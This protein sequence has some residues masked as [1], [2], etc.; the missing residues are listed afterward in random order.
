MTVRVAAVAAALLLL[1]AVQASNADADG[2]SE[3]VPANPVRTA[4][5]GGPARDVVDYVLGAPADRC[6]TTPAARVCSWHLAPGTRAHAALVEDGDAGAANAPVHVVCAFTESPD[7]SAKRPGDCSVHHPG[8][9]IARRG[10]TLATLLPKDEA[11]AALAAASDVEALARAFGRAPDDCLQR[12]DEEWICS[13]VTRPAEPG[14]ALAGALAGTREA[15]R[16]V[17]RLPL[18]GGER[19][20]DS[21][22]AFALR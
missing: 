3:S 6:T 14:H 16:V 8:A 11:R 4:L 1:P 13:F 19:A 21:C 15:A 10:R 5:A 17:C 2:A 7:G 20:P 22:R 18:A 12:D 9:A